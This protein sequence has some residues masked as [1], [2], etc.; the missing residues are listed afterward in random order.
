MKD[1]KNHLFDEMPSAA[2]KL[3]LQAGLKGA[4]YR[5]K[6]VWESLEGIHV[7]PFYH[8]DEDAIATPDFS[9][10]AAW[11]IAENFYVGNIKSCKKLIVAAIQN[12][13]DSLILE[14]DKPFDAAYL[15][16]ELPKNPH[17]VYLNVNFCDAD[18]FEKFILLCRELNIKL[19]L[20]FDPIGHLA[21]TGNWFKNLKE[22]REIFE[23]LSAKFPDISVAGIHASVY[24]EAGAHMVQQLAYTL[25]QLA[26][27]SRW[28]SRLPFTVLQTVGSN[29]FFEIAKIKALRW[30]H[31]S[32]ADKLQSHQPLHILAMPGKRNKTLYDYNVNL[33]R[34][35][36]EC[37][38]AVLGGADEVANLPYDAFFKKDHA[39][40][41]RLARNQLL[42]LK[43]ES[44]L[45]RVQNPAQGT[46]Y[47]ESL[48]QALAE[49]ALLLFKQTEKE[50]GLLTLLKK[51]TVQEKVAQSHQKE[52][53]M[54][55][56]GKLVLVGTTRYQDKSEQARNRSELYPFVKSRPQKTLIKPL[57]ARR[58]AENIE[59]E[60]L[61]NEN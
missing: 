32:L 47:I 1:A 15:L 12:G 58:L 29:Y 19:H 22:D 60:R 52:Q 48:T 38:S 9:N 53:K 6:L 17:C 34:S 21:Q 24:Q 40:S 57:I 27:Y 28:N 59:K 41:R 7:K 4:D 54:L 56:E 35:T 45:N 2:W 33:L 42:I 51:G 44:F 55:Q 14:A 61:E 49:K 23:N 11:K 30:L 36:T 18:F 16:S 37:M 43:E 26:E 10:Q 39:F 5:E 20:L 8:A 25:A 31:A 13:T 50:G 46:Y 3:A